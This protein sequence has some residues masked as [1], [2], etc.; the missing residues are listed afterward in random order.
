MGLGSGIQVSKRHPIR[1]RN[2]APLGTQ[3][4]KFHLLWRWR[5]RVWIIWQ[6]ADCGAAVPVLPPRPTVLSLSSCLVPGRIIWQLA[7]C[8]AAVPVL[9][10]RPTVFSP[11]SCLVPGRIIWQLADCGAAVP[12][13]PPPPTVLSPSSCLV[14]SRISLECSN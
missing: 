6:L 14:Q 4:A 11:S 3:P 5:G 7:D 9:P 13:L 10:P 1:I 12:A 8:G 2:T